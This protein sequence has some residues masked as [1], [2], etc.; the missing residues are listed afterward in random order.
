MPNKPIDPETTTWFGQWAT[1]NKDV[2]LDP[3]FLEAM[4]SNDPCGYEA[5]QIIYESMRKVAAMR[6]EEKDKIRLV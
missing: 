6:D 5:W 4:N 2:E 3:R 1:L